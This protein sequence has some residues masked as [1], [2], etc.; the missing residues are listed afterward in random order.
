MHASP[1]VDTQ[2]QDTYFIVAHLH[3]VLVGGALTGIFAG[4]YYWMPK[5]TGRFLSERIGKVQFWLWF[6]GVNLTFFPMHYLG[7]IGMP[8]RI[9]TYETGFGWDFWNL[10][11]TVGSYI[12]ALSVLLFVI[13]FFRSM[14]QPATAGNNPWE[15][16]TLEWATSS[17]PPEHDFDVI[18]AVRAR[19]PL[20]YDR[21]HGI[22]PAQPTGEHIHLPPP[23]YY[24]ILIGAGVLLMAVG[25]LTNLAM[26]ALGI[27]IVIYG[28]WG[29]A[30]EPTD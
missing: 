30:L 8:R 9:Y 11:Q 1:P 10:W 28:T 4:L 7:L 29:W 3:Y 12:I 16:G 2:Q 20:W 17:P 21:D 22:A 19:D 13:N 24:P 5:M 6:V 18:P 25:P 15:G 26:T 23:S 27:V 14:R